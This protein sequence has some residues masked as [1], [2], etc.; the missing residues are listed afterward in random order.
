VRK[1]K[2]LEEDWI[3]WIVFVTYLVDRT[4]TNRYK[5]HMLTESTLSTVL[6]YI[7]ALPIL[8]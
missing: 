4:L 1:E 2:S 3:E 8:E 5:L 7:Y 6:F